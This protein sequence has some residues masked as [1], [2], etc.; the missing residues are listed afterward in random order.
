MLTVIIKI[1]IVSIHLS[2][3][4]WQVWFSIE[5]TR[6]TFYPLSFDLKN[7]INHIKASGICV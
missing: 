3:N 4:G 5:V 1:I 2:A 7:L 6:L